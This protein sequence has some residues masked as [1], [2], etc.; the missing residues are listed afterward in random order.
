M[1]RSLPAVRYTPTQI[2]VNVT[3]LI[4]TD[5]YNREAGEGSRD[6]ETE[7][8]T[9]DR[10]IVVRFPAR[11]M[12]PYL[13]HSVQ[14]VIGRRRP[15]FNKFRHIFPP[16]I[17]ALNTRYDEIYTTLRYTSI[18]PYSFLSVGSLITHFQ[19]RVNRILNI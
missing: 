6:M 5:L 13:L 2:S 16:G 3:F 8:L 15:L 7:S 18:P 9:T 11:T 1:Y 17:K 4:I 12:T 10:G 14:T 19:Y